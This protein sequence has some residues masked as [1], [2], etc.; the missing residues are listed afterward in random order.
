MEGILEAGAVSAAASGPE[1][2]RGLLAE[3]VGGAAEQ[4]V[5]GSS[6]SSGLQ[7]SCL[8]PA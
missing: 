2:L 7:R 3:L 8:I 6:T 5:L 4:V 1:R